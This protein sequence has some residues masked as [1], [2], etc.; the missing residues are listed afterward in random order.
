VRIRLAGLR[1]TLPLLEWALVV[2]V[3]VVVQS[4]KVRL[5]LLIIRLGMVLATTVHQFREDRR[6]NVTRTSQ[7]PARSPG[8][9]AQ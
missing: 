1:A 7:R 8:P 4:P 3:S 2:L 5:V 6:K 9:P